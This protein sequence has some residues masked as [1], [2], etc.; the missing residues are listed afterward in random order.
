MLYLA[1]TANL[2]ELE[3]LTDWFPLAGITTNPSILKKSGMKLSSAFTE[4]SCL[5][6]NRMLHIQLISDMADDMVKEAFQYKSILNENIS[7]YVKIPVTR[8]GYRAMQLLKEQGF[9]I[10]ATAVFTHQQALVAAQAG[11]D[12]I[13]PYVDR[14]EQYNS[15]GIQLVTDLSKSLMDFHLETQILAASFKTVE[16]VQQASLAGAHAVALNYDLLKKII[17][18]PLTDKAVDQFRED[19]QSV[20]DVPR[21]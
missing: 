19:G 4:L 6:K 18:H 5:A 16:Q 8:E 12:F 21:K 10:T 20:Y 7:L 9:H 11:V 15:Q 1:D 14:L 3:E 13:A 2:K 17:Q